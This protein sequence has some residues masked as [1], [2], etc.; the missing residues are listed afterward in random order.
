MKDWLVRKY[1]LRAN[2]I[3]Q[4]GGLSPQNLENTEVMTRLDEL[5]DRVKNHPALYSYWIIDEPS[6]SH[7][8]NIGRLVARIRL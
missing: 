1:G 2:L 4:T 7:F 8:P 3:V 5:I 6:V